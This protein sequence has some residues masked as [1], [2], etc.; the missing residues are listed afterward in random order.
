MGAEPKRNPAGGPGFET[1]H[2]IDDARSCYRTLPAQGTIRR[3][4]LDALRSGRRLTSREVWAEFG[5]TRLAADV[6][7]LR[8]LGWSIDAEEIVVECRAGR[9]THVAQYSL[10]DGA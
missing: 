5:G 9:T 1:E 7:E 6:H 2:R 10:A 8:R 3:Q 4:I